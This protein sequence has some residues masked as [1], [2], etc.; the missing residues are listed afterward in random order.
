MDP[1]MPIE[2]DAIANSLEDFPARNLRRHLR[3]K[4]SKRLAAADNSKRPG[5]CQCGGNLILYK[6]DT[7]MSP[8]F[9]HYILA[10]FL[11]ISLINFFFTDHLCCDSMCHGK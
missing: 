4:R 11:F 9:F 2:E 3:R 5:C 6:K 10:N 7:E 1:G 8:P